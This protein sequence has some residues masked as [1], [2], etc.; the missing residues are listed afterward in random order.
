M[1]DRMSH[2]TLLINRVGWDC[3]GEH[4]EPCP[5]AVALRRS[6]PGDAPPA[7][8]PRTAQWWPRPRWRPRPRRCPPARR[9]CVLSD[10]GR[11]ALTGPP[12]AGP[13]PPGAVGPRPPAAD[14]GAPAPLQRTLD[15]SDTRHWMFPRS[16]SW[17]DVLQRARCKPWP[18]VEGAKTYIFPC[19]AEIRLIRLKRM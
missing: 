13:R 5:P 12:A 18:Y 7:G 4:S 3:R 16:R 15:I 1:C 8:A 14:G 19:Q 17:P 6:L 10:P 2:T 11:R 9:L